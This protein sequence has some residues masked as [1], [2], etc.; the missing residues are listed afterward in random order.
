MEILR[1]T[2]YP[3]SVTYTVTA[4]NTSHYLVISTNDRYE[5]LVSVAVT[6]N[7]S[8]V[9][10]YTLPDSFYKYDDYYALEIYEKIGSSRGD[11]L[12]EDNLEIVRPYV[13]PNTLGTT[14]TEI[15]QY[16]E[17]ESLARNIIDAY[18]PDGFYFKKE[19]VQAVGQGTDYFSIWKRGY[20]VLKAYENA[21]K[22]WD[23]DDE[24]GPA[25]DNYDYSIT[26][27]KTAIV[28]DPSSGV[29]QW[30]RAERKPAKM[31]IAASDSFSWFDTADS[32]NI[33][34]F[35]GGVSFP[36][37]VDYMFYLE[38]GY[39]VVPNDVKDAA[40]MLIDD[41]KCG[42]LDY[43]KRY[44]DSYRT[45]QFTVQYNKSMMQGTGN[46]LVDKIL[47]KYVNLVTR[48]GVL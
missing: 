31:A 3:L 16:T 35:T 24:D 12:I 30:D 1:V 10:T 4:A 48:P 20:R 40:N 22:V 34:T 6:S 29:D 19:W 42:K 8:S 15:A 23:V 45:D 14:A 25:L 5:E 36:E 18:V 37:G 47:D 41:I 27:D 46:L 32:A 13:D 39:K 9:I 33:Q 17:Y 38:T 2:P 44:V 26:K 11:I 7:S 28:K 21:E 43:Y